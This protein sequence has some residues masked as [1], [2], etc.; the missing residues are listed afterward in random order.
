M[1]RS[2]LASALLI[3]PLL[4]AAPACTR[5]LAAPPAEPVAI[6]NPSVETAAARD[7]VSAFVT[8]EA[9][10]DEAA[11]TLVSADADFIATGIAVTARP[12]LAGMIGRGE[13]TIEEARTELAG[14]FA[15]VTVVYRWVGRTPDSAER[16]RATFVL[17]RR[18]AG[19]RIRHV[20]SSMVERWE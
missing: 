10:G 4:A 2:A 9:R 5:R 12:R 17:E 13:G 18:I 14:S 15:W 8:A 6:G 3:L 16:A 11:D 7:V 19:W 20:H 1:P